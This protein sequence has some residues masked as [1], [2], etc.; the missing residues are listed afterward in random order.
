MR[1]RIDVRNGEVNDTAVTTWAQ[2]DETP[3]LARTKKIAAAARFAAYADYGSCDSCGNCAPLLSRSQQMNNATASVIAA[4]TC[5][6]M[7]SFPSALRKANDSMRVAMYAPIITPISGITVHLLAGI[8][9][10]YAGAR[11]AAP[12]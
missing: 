12:R 6:T 3:L 4:H 1:D 5:V 2:G 7:C 9:P 10:S 8:A 11:A